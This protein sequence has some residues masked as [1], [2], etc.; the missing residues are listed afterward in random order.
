MAKKKGDTKKDI[1]KSMRDSGAG[2]IAK[3]DAEFLKKRRSQ[4]K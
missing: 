4:K 1:D 2:S 3:A